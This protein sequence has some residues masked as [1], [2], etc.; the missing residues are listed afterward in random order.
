MF[1]T[2][3]VLRGGAIGDFVLTLPVLAALRGLA[4]IE[5][6]GYPA[7]ASL[8][9]AG[10]L[11]DAVAALEAP[12]FAP[13]FVRNGDLPEDAVRYLAGFDLIIS[14]LHD[15]EGIF[16]ENAA[17][18]SNARYLQGPHRPKESVKLHATEVLLQPL[19]EDRKSTRLN[20]SH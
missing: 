20:S 19:R 11:A 4:R 7:I 10:G 14:Y 5:V 15:P 2:I 16:R 3:L 6:L 13:F 17:R 9:V 8:A 18:C 12:R 1:K